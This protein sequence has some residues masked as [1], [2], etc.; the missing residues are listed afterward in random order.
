MSDHH[1]AVRC[2]LSTLLLCCLSAGLVAAAGG[3]GKPA[4]RPG[5]GFA[6][7]GKADAERAF[8]RQVAAVPGPQGGQPAVIGMYLWGGRA[9]ENYKPFFQWELRLKAGSAA[10]AGLR[11]RVVTLGPLKEI[12]SEGPWQ[13]LGSL[14]A[15]ASK[16]VSY[17][18][19]G[20]NFAAFQVEMQ[21]Q[22]GKQTAIAGDKFSV[23]IPVGDLIGSAALV[24]TNA[25][26]DY[27]DKKKN[28]AAAWSLWNLGG[29]A[30]NDVVLTIR[31]LDDKGK[32]V[33]TAEWKPDQGVVP[34]GYCKEHRHIVSGV[35]AF[36]GI[37][38]SA[39]H[40]GSGSGDGVV[41]GGSFTGA[42]DVEVAKIRAEGKLLKAR[43]RNGTD[44]D[45]EGV[46]VTLRLLGKDGK[47]LRKVDLPVAKLAKGA[48]QDVEATLGDGIT[49]TSFEVGWAA[50]KVAPPLGT[51]AATAPASNIAITSD[52]VVFTQSQVLAK[53]GV[54]LIKGRLVNRR[55]QDLNGLVVTFKLTSKDKSATSE[56][57][58]E[59]LDN[60]QS[61]TVILEVP[62]FT[63]FDGLSMNWKAAAASK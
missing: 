55:G 21:W 10:L 25:N 23:P 16:D 30:A 9:D 31:F 6:E 42:K 2:W 33:K 58:Q 52:G 61:A 11:L 44:N 62:G 57:R 51:T 46:V 26:H 41:D 45:L 4:P 15:S 38:I 56:F 7:S 43:V 17:R 39:R 29:K 19:N 32:E 40:S 36:T 37:S 27:D 22:G 1:L 53:D 24:I 12:G 20:P 13:D 14:A 50:G 47:E 54:L 28:A 59:R 48:E 35:P 63:A 49:W 3:G 8:A 34:P 18:I 5:G 60:E